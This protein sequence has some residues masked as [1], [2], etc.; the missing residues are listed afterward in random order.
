MKSLM[1]NVRDCE[2]TG[3]IGLLPE[4]V[5]SCEDLDIMPFRDGRGAA[6]DVME[7]LLI[8]LPIGGLEA[9]LQALGAMWY[10]R[11]QH[12]D[13]NRYSRFGYQSPYGSLSN[14]LN[15]FWERFDCTLYWTPKTRAGDFEDDIDEIIELAE[16]SCTREHCQEDMLEE[17]DAYKAQFLNGVRHFMRR[18]ISKMRKKFPDAMD[19][20]TL[21]WNIAEAID[22]IIEQ[23]EHTGQQFRLEYNMT[24]GE[25]S[26]EAYYEEEYYD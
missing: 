8:G 24:T 4:N 6:H 17:H 13:L 15:S 25:A 7:H 9:E 5:R 22:G 20:N 12:D 11:G 23:I 14:D 1:L 19:G 21:F 2:M 26:C 16:E 10:L 3:E 18:G